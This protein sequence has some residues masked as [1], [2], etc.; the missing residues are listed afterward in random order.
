MRL[1]TQELAKLKVYIK[2]DITPKGAYDKFAQEQSLENLLGGGF[3][4][5]EEW[6]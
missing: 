2:I 3:I 4:T 1:D 5:F 6:F